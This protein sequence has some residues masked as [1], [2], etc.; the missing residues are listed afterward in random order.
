MKI[1]IVVAQ[2]FH[3]S[4]LFLLV[5]SQVCVLLYWRIIAK[6][7]R[8]VNASIWF[9]FSFFPLLCNAIHRWATHNTKECKM[10][11][12]LLILFG[13]LVG[14]VYIRD[15]IAYFSPETCAK[16]KLFRALVNKF[17]ISCVRCA[18]AIRNDTTERNQQQKTILRI[19]N[20]TK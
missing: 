7:T 5:R 12:L 14:I 16:P 13:C 20:E 2:S 17:S 10:W 9:F 1:T 4:Q 19:S 8:T 6:R 11:R 18:I 3:F 15:W